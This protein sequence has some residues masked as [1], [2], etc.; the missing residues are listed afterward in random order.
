[1][2]GVRDRRRQRIAE[3]GARLLERDPVLPKVADLLLRVP[4]ESH[5]RSISG[6]RAT[7]AF[8][9]GDGWTGLAAAAWGATPDCSIFFAS[10]KSCTPR[11][12]PLHSTLRMG[13]MQP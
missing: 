1:M 7:R 13:T 11:P 5:P 6:K 2:L 8:G 4:F 3:H 10:P 12:S 9:T